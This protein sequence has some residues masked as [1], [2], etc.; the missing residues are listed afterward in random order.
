MLVVEGE[1][2]ELVGDVG[3]MQGFIMD[4]RGQLS[5]YRVFGEWHRQHVERNQPW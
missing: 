1:V 4:N 5:F 2:R 3:L